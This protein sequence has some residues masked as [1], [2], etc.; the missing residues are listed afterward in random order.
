MQDEFALCAPRSSQPALQLGRVSDIAWQPDQLLPPRAV[1]PPS[2]TSL[3][4]S[5]RCDSVATAAV[6]Q[7]LRRVQLPGRK[8]TPI[9]AMIG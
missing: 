2:S 6:F 4:F 7:R 5:H 3:I 1:A 9:R 8:M